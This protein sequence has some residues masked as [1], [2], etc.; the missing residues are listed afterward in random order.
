MTDTLSPADPI[1]TA[2]V[3]VTTPVT[4]VVVTRGRTRYL[5]TT[6]R[7]VA[8][9]S[10]RPLRVLVVDV[11][12]ADER[13]GPVL[14]EAFAAVPGP[15][16]RLSTVRAPQART[17]GEAVQAGLDA[18]AEALGERPTTW[19]WLL[20]DDSAPAPEAL[21]RLVRTVSNAPSVA[22]AGCKQRTW[23]DPERL[24]EV[25]VRTTR[26]GRR[27]TD[28]E[29]GELDQ[30]QHDGRTDV[31]GVGIA[32][33]LVR[34]DVW[35]ALG[36]TDPALDRFGDGLD[37]SRRA[38]LA[39]H[40]VVVVPTA[41][42]RHAQASYHGLRPTRGTESD[43]A[44]G[45][46]DLDGDG[47]PDSADPTRSFAARRR[48][49]LHQRLA[50][51]P[52][53]LVPLVAAMTLAV[54][55]LRSLGQ[56]AAKHPQLAVAELRVAILVLL[57]P[58]PVVRARRR[59]RASR[60]LPRRT[61]RPLQATW[62]DVWQQAR[63][64]RLARLEERRLVRAPS[65]LELRE[66]AL[67]ATRRRVTLAVVAVVLGL[68]SAAAVGRLLSPVAAG[69]P[70]VGDA[71][72]R[73]T[74]G[75][76]DL[77]AAATSGWVAAGV[78][79]P[80]PA[81]PLLVVLAVL[82]VL[83][84]GAPTAGVAVLVL[85]AVVLSGL[86]AWAAAG[87]A[88][89]SVVV[90]AWA[91]FVWA[92]APALLLAVGDG[93]VGA[94]VA[95]TALPWVAL[96]LARAVGVQRV[97]QVLS[98][99]STARREVDE[100]DADV[101]ADERAAEAAR[102]VLGADVAPVGVRASVAAEHGTTGAEHGLAGAEHGTGGAEH[103]TAGAEHAEVDV[104]TPV[105]GVGVVPAPRAPGSGA[106]PV[107][108]PATAAGSTGSAAPPAD[109]AAVVA[110]FVGAP[111]PTGSVAAAAG[112]A[113]ALAVAVAA[114]PVL[115][116]PAV[117][118]VVVV[119]ATV[120]R[121]RVRVLGVLVPTLV[122]L[123]P[124]LVEVGTRGA[125]GVR[126]LL[127]EPGP[128]TPV[129]PAAAWSRA[130]GVP[131]DP[132]VLVPAGLPDVL[133]VAWPYLT[134][135]V[136][137]LLAAGALLRG[138]PV[139]RGVRVCWAVAAVGVAAGAAVAVL[140]AAA[141]ADA[142]GP[143]W[144]G[145]TV[146]LTTLGLLGAAV[147]GSDRLTARLARQSFGWRQP[148][149]AVTTVVAVVAVACGTLGWAWTA[150]TGDA[151]ALRASGEPVVPVV[152]QQ[153]GRSTASSRVLALTARGDG[154]VDFSLLR[155]DGDQHVDHAAAVTT[156]ALTGSLRA[157]VVAAPDDAAAEVAAL[158]ARLVQGAAGDVAHDVGA[159]G[160]AD[161]LVPAVTQDDAQSR[162]ARA[163][164]VGV[165]D[166]TAG[167]ERVTHDSSATLWR[168]RPAQGEVVTSW[169]R[170]LGAGQDVTDPAAGAVAVPA[171][172]R[173]IGTTV[174]GG[175]GRR[176]LVLAERAD[177]GWHAWLDGRELPAVDAGWR[178]AFELGSD[179][180][181]LEVRYVSP[182]RAPWVAALG[183]TT[184]VTVLLALPLRRRRGV[185]T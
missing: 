63:D 9:Q 19:L 133:A 15:A 157:P 36:G 40:R 178:Q 61:L 54:A 161:V 158:A 35:D 153:A 34:R 22:V 77:W 69:A 25:G 90:R 110:T 142:V 44:P 114:A 3:P 12:P 130:L 56:V 74:T 135:A 1:T 53:P 107:A 150:R 87:A 42:V 167:L 96:G 16:P 125:A 89:R 60:V 4:A 76:G 105:R 27:M 70:L 185:R 67:L 137:V 123:A 5:A 132:A 93:R 26:S 81:D 31:L 138:R 182:Q 162:A 7:A 97:D 94:V 147:L 75:P 145:A 134:G 154:S 33:A 14:D 64:R 2:A 176:V 144:T 111:D 23:T 83:L 38:R 159:L 28:V 160:V 86:G 140:P 32:G 85:G 165:L 139:A 151:V 50:S 143:A 124:F 59:A 52:L 103:G 172:G 164:L 131:A 119:A 102:R 6:L 58:G 181:V 184:L 122:L 136:L 99:I 127:A 68:L 91:A 37:L 46:V 48:S 128:A 168:V 152:G 13:V 121:A 24:L 57:R 149:V 180:G 106:V 100:P 115:L 104:V 118:L 41:V 174:P 45:E 183:L 175:D 66:L 55:V 116:V 173:A 171:E 71:L 18:L 141:G 11:A 101:A 29:P 43:T 166:A 84:G 49:L 156:R 177:P 155:S 51:A 62:R 95:H 10:R 109:E 79:A 65:E 17:F 21:A 117:L 39:G 179:G 98:G 8:T 146:S 169:A 72:A 20:H 129:E 92:S 88:T 47:E 170:L 120:P 163:R 113:L 148:L 126:L 112:A 78:G 108:R 80:G 82:A 73:T 30:G